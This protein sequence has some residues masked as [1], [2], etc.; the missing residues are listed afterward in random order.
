MQALH[1]LCLSLLSMDEGVEFWLIRRYPWG[2][3]ASWTEAMG[4]A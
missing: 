1:G 2:W 3:K 4:W